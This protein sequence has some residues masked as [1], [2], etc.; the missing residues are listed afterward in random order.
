MR[1]RLPI[2]LVSLFIV[3]SIAATCRRPGIVPGE[4][5][6]MATY[7]AQT[8]SA[9][10][11]QLTQSAMALPTQTPQPT[12]TPGIPPTETSLPPTP[13]Q[14]LPTPTPGVEGCIDRAVFIDDVTIP[15]NTMVAADSQLVKTWR[16][17]NG[18]DCTWTSSYALVFSHG[19][20]LGGPAVQPF[21]GAV[22]PGTTIDLTVNLTAPA[23]PG[24]YQSF[25]KLRNNV[26]VL[27]GVGSSGNVAFWMKIIVPE[28]SITV[29]LEYISVESGQVYSDGSLWPTE[30]VGDG[31][32]DLGL[33]AFLS[34]DFSGI[35]A[36]AT[37][38]QVQYDFTDFSTVGSPFSDLNCLRAYPHYY[39][40]LN[41][42]DYFVGSEPGAIALWCDVTEMQSILNA[43]A[44]ALGKFQDA[45]GQ[46]RFQMRLQFNTVETDIDGAEDVVRFGVPK[47]I[48]TYK[49]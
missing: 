33:Q 43:N 49:P 6:A 34:F 40:V 24:T 37:L 41:A 3:G 18:G 14:A 25:W 29:T 17:K 12:N 35:P 7:A 39:G 4:F 44:F 10:S 48:I 31:D 20:Q 13:T 32:S 42:N 47:L 2:F 38:T 19:D 15:D 23:S 27:F 46:D 45:L 5:D 21:T 22:A 36:S 11:A 30:N 9:V 1:H 8:I 26:G 28:P 16:I